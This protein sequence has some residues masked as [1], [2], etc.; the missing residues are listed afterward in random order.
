MPSGKKRI[1]DPAGGK[2]LPGRELTFETALLVAGF[3]LF[4]VLLFEL[5]TPAGEVH[6]LNPP[7]IAAAGAILLWP[8]RKQRTVRALLLAGGFLILVWFLSRIGVVLLPFLFVYVLAYLFDPVVELARRKYGVPRWILALL[9]TFVIIGFF[10]LVVFLLVPSVIGQ[11]EELAARVLASLTY[12]REWLMTSAVLDELE[13][14]GLI[15]KNDIILQISNAI[16]DQ[17]ARITTGIPNIVQSVIGYAGSILGLI[18]TMAIIPVIL[19][20]TLKDYPFITRRLIQLFPTY[21]GRR[22]YLVK[23]GEVVGNYLRGQIIISAIGAFNV[24]LVLI[25]FDVPFALL[26]GLL[27]GV[28]NMIPNLG[29]I[30]TNVIGILIAVV[31]GDPWFIDALIVF[32]TLLGQSFLETMILSP[33][34]LSEQVGLHPVLILLSL[35]VFGYFLGMFGLLI[36]VPATALIMTVY[37]TYRSEF[38]LELGAERAGNHPGRAIRQR[39]RSRTFLTNDVGLPPGAPDPPLSADA[40]S[41]A[42]SD[43]VTPSPTEASS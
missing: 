26:I 4:I 22:D 30:L 1:A 40:V 29:A 42:S 3:V 17:A 20:Y 12:L 19:Y 2:A 38:T 31:F 33:K 21:G 13:T 16:Q 5:R 36:A 23:A 6:F 41:A 34:I 32:L 9:A 10:T 11:L 15:E 8:L 28:L 7:L 37:K 35:L 39:K 43:G 24:S 14:S 18:T 25:L 27:A